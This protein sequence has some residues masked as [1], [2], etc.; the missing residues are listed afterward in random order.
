MSFF[1]GFIQIY[2]TY[3]PAVGLRVRA[4]VVD[5]FDRSAAAGS[6]GLRVGVWAAASVSSITS[7]GCNSF[8]RTHPWKIP[9]VLKQ[10]RSGLLQLRRRRYAPHEEKLSFE[11]I[12]KQRPPPPDK[13]TPLHYYAR[14]LRHQVPRQ[15]QH[16]EEA[17]TP[18][19][20]QV[21]VALGHGVAP[22]AAAS[23]GSPRSRRW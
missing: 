23:S 20:R 9:R 2:W 6:T 16:E 7:S 17:Q 22:A 13:T 19:D 15:Q 4:V 21:L 1:V 10:S 5:A 12:R 18:E 8:A 3:S 11:V 14:S